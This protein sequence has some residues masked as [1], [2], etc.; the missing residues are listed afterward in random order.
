MTRGERAANHLKR[1]TLEHEAAAKAI[2]NGTHKRGRRSGGAQT[3]KNDDA[4]V[5]LERAGL[6]GFDREV[7]FHLQRQWK[8]DFFWRRER[9]GLE[10]EGLNRFADHPGQHRSV[11]GFTD[12]CI[13][14][15]EAAIAGVLLVRVTTAHVEDG[16]TAD[17]CTMVRLVRRAL[18]ARREQL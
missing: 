3:S 16:A 2:R 8:L 18:E 14:Y 5:V 15:S 7:R 1:G 11:E 9:V 13:K 17:D 4:A 12:N 10:V 6:G